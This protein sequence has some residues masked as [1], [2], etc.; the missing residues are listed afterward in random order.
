MAI[1][2]IGN[3][4]FFQEIKYIQTPTVSFIG[5]F[6]FRISRVI[7]LHGKIYRF[8]ILSAGV[9]LFHEKQNSSFNDEK[10]SFEDGRLSF[11]TS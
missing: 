8:Q 5:P 11:M 4:C 10:Q 1:S 3:G 2:G 7:K 6:L 9:G